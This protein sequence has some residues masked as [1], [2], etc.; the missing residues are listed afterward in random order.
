M[1]A[2]FEKI[3]AKLLPPRT[4]IAVKTR[5]LDY[6]RYSSQDRVDLRPRSRTPRPVVKPEK[7]SKRWKKAD[8]LSVFTLRD[9]GKSWEEIIRILSAHTAGSARSRCHYY[10]K[11]QDNAWE[12]SI[13]PGREELPTLKK[14]QQTS[15]DAR[16]RKFIDIPMV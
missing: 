11:Q 7:T 3:S 2:R 15:M 8:L 10:K 1:R 9:A 4:T 16:K 12:T 14:N 6:L 13:T 5:C